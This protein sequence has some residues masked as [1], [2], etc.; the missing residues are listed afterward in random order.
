M[1]YVLATPIKYVEIDN[2][3]KLLKFFLEQMIWFGEMRYKSLAPDEASS[4]YLLRIQENADQKKIRILDTFYAV[5]MQMTRKPYNDMQLIL[6]MGA[7]WS[8]MMICLFL[9]HCGQLI[10]L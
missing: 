1:L 8:R 10:R 7:F 4:P 5:Q 2:L 3:H 9:L 6:L